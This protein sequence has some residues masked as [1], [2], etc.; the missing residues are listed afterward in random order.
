MPGPSRISARSSTAF[1]SRSSSPRRACAWQ[2]VDMIAQRSA[3]PLSTAERRRSYGR[4]APPHAA[5]DARLELRPPRA[6]PN[7]I[8][9]S[10]FPCSPADGPSKPRRRWAATRPATDIFDLPSSSSKSRSWRSSRRATAIACSRR[11]GNIR[12]HGWRRPASAMTRGKGI[13]R[14]VSR[15]PSGRGRGCSVRTKSRATRS[16]TS[17]ATTCAWRIPGPRIRGTRAPR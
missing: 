17:R 12:R 7:R 6:L 13:F 3:R 15:W 10:G 2:S 1:R 14:I 11:S 8:C 5:G 9:S 4:P 16:S